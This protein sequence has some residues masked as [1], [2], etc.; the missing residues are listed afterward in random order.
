MVRRREWFEKMADAFLVLW[1]VPAGETPTVDDAKARLTMLRE[2][3][4]TADAFT[5]R[6]S[7]PRPVE[8][9]PESLAGA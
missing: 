7:F 9:A 6:S 1:W 8:S 2:R 3:G 4:P 5:V